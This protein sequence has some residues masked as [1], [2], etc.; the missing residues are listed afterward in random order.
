MPIGTCDPATRGDPYNVLQLAVGNGDV[1]VTIRYGWDGTST[2]DIG[3]DGPLVN[4][5]GG[6]NVWAISYLNAGQ[7]TYIM[8][9]VGK[10]G[11]IRTLTL[12]PGASGTFNKAQAASRGYVNKSDVE[13]LTLTPA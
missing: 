9:T 13:D 5:T 8:R 10:N 12:D 3:C 7:T 6:G 4:G 11:Q 2:R 1:F